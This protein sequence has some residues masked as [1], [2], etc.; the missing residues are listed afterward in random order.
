MP[1]PSPPAP[2]RS[3]ASPSLHDRLNRIEGHMRGLQ[4]MVRNDRR[5]ID[6]VTQV[7]AVQAALNTVALRLRHDGGPHQ[8]EHQTAELM[9]AVAWLL[10]RPRQGKMP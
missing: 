9:A 6:V 7:Q 8:V 1:L 2:Y 5:C 10:R 4:G 3:G